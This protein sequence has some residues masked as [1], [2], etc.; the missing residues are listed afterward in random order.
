MKDTSNMQQL[1]GHATG[2]SRSL[3]MDD[4]IAFGEFWKSSF[5]RSLEMDDNI[6]FGEFWKSS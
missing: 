4:N 3:E 5:S 1:H 6:A 2:F